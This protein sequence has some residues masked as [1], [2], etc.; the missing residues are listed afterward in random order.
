[1]SYERELE[2]ALDAVDLAGRAILEDYAQFEVVPD[3]PASITTQTDRR[4]QEIIL[5]CLKK[6]FP[7]DGLCA[8]E[9]TE[10]LGRAGGVSPL[11]KAPSRLWIID[12]IDGTRGFAR[13]TGEF[14]VMVG[15]VDQG[16]I[17]VGVVS[18]PARGR[19]TYAVRGGGCWRRDNSLVTAEAC[20]VST[21]SSLAAATLTQSH[22]RKTGRPSPQ[23]EALAPARIV[24][25]Y[26]AGIK[27]ALVA[28]AEADLY[29]NTYDRYHDWDICA[30]QILVTE[31]GGRVTYLHGQSPRYGLPG[32]V[33]QHGLLA[34][35]GVLQ[36][37]ALAALAK[38]I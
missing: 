30:G 4:S 28:R 10:T 5:K 37:P 23:L 29:L 17:A 21:V 14:S 27:L 31:A 7:A 3:A 12:P 24:E 20:R 9:A 16:E 19:L 11:M 36:E 8:E 13:K 38:G 26:S 34:T 2:V 6:A 15:L 22:S 1:M 33:Q 25:S 35:N 18:E 32:A